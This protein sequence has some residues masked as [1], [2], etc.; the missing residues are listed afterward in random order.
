MG[1]NALAPKVLAP[2]TLEKGTTP[3]TVYIDSAK[4][5][6]YLEY[7]SY[8]SLPV[9]NENYGTIVVYEGKEYRL[10]RVWELQLQVESITPSPIPS[11]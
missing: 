9:K 1:C 8:D 2:V 5:T 10:E 4:T 3:W 7:S 6:W 11:P